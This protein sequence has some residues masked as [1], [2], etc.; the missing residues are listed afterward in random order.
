LRCAFCFASAGGRH[1]ADPSL[2]AIE[3][4]YRGLLDVGGPYN[5]QLSGGEPC[6]RDDLPE[7]IALGRSLGFTFFQ[8]NTNGLRLARDQAYLERLVAAGLNTVFLQFDGTRDDIHKALRA[9]NLLTIKQQAVA[10]CAKHHVGVVLVPTLVPGINTDNIGQIVDYA[11]GH[12]PV[13]RGV[14]FQPASYFG[15]YPKPPTDEDRFTL[16]EVISAIEHQSHGRIRAESFLPP[17]GENALCSFHGN[18]VVMP[19][20]Q[21]R[22][23]TRHLNNSCCQPTPAAEGATR[24]RAFVAKNWAAPE[25][26][27]N[28]QPAPRSNPGFGGWETFLS[29]A[30]TH[31][32]CISGMA[33]QDAWTL[34]LERLRDCYIHTASP[35]GRIIPFCAYNLT[36]QFGH[37]LYRSS[38]TAVVA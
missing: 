3:N 13:V 18:F 35:D 30:K 14:H 32:F 4:W 7:I 28:S 38:Q 23:L 2:T 37:A 22:P 29:R 8:V 19:D 6:Q 20:G 27:S 36:D 15:R 12:F 5:I 26:A 1:P 11:L 25:S 21:L 24:S 17:G 33:F 31:V 34:D 10:N 16:P 9:R